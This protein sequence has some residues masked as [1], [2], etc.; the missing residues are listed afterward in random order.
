LPEAQRALAA[1][2]VK[3]AQAR[4]AAIAASQKIAADALAALAKPGSQ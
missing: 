1:A 2:W 4:E 3:T